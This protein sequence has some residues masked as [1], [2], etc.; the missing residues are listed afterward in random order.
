MRYDLED[1]PP[2]TSE[3]TEKVRELFRARGLTV[4]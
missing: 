4:Y 2:P 1:T 3:E